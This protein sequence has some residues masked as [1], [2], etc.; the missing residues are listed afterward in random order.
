VLDTS[1][2]DNAWRMHLGE[3]ATGRATDAPGFPIE[4][5]E[6]LVAALKRLVDFGERPRNPV[7]FPTDFHAF[8]HNESDGMTARWLHAMGFPTVRAPEYEGESW[9]GP[10]HVVTAAKHWS[11]S[12]LK[13]AFADATV[14]GRRLVVFSE[15]GFTGPA[16]KWAGAASV[17]L[18]SWP[19]SHD[20]ISP[21]SAAAH[22]LMPQ[23]L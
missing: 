1:D 7:K 15:R 9:G 10:F 3:L 21:R 11:L 4:D 18:F 14:A 12:A 20:H 13:A 17:P 22:V 6:F 5:T 2:E 23:V 8:A 19:P 16:E